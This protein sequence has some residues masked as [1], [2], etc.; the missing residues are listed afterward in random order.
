MTV[1]RDVVGLRDASALR[2][3]VASIAIL[4]VIGLLACWLPTRR[5]TRISPSLA[6]RSD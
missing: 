5:V 3:F 2:P 4:A 1:A 6:L